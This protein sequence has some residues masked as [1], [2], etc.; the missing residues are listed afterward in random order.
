MKKIMVDALVEEVPTD[1]ETTCN[2][3]KYK[4]Y[5]KM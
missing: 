2:G 4:A 1:L 5:W 3:E